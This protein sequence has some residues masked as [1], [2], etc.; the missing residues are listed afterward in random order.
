MTSK[1]KVKTRVAK[2]LT[3]ICESNE[4]FYLDMLNFKSETEVYL[5]FIKKK[6]FAI[7]NNFMCRY[8]CDICA[9]NFAMD[10][11][12]LNELTPISCLSPD[13]LAENSRYNAFHFTNL[14]EK[15]FEKFVDLQSGCKQQFPLA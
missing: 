9:I 1:W 2:F 8:Y 10:D 5:L 15:V 11:L 13:D 14:S 4:N 7:N 12:T 3:E 6:I